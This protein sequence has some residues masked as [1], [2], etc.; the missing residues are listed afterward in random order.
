MCYIPWP[1][2]PLYMIFNTP[3]TW[4]KALPYLMPQ[5]ITFAHCEDIEIERQLQAILHSGHIQPSASRG[6]PNFI[7]PQ[8]ETNE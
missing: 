8:R 7:I 2:F 3:L 5:H 6:S 4:S 1:T